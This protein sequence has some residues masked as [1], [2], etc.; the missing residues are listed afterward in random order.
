MSSDSSVIWVQNRLEIISK[1]DEIIFGWRRPL[2]NETG[3]HKGESEFFGKE[4]AS[5]IDKYYL[6]AD[7]YKW[8][9]IKGLASYRNGQIYEMS[10]RQIRV[11]K[12]LA[13]NKVN[14][15]HDECEQLI[16]ILEEIVILDRD[17][18]FFFNKKSVIKEVF[19]KIYIRASQSSDLIAVIYLARFLEL[20]VSANPE[21]FDNL[22]VEYCPNNILYADVLSLLI[23]YLNNA[24]L[25]VHDRVFLLWVSLQIVDSKPEIKVS[26]KL[27]E[28]VNNSLTKIA[29]YISRTVSVL[30]DPTFK[31]TFKLPDPTL[32][33]C[34]V[35][36]SL[37]ATN[38]SL[39]LL[40]IISSSNSD[41]KKFDKNIP[42]YLDQLKEGILVPYLKIFNH[43]I[44]SRTTNYRESGIE[45]EDSFLFPENHISNGIM[46]I[47]NTVNR[48]LS[49]MSILLRSYFRVGSALRVIDPISI[50]K[51]D[52]DNT[53]RLQLTHACWKREV[54]YEFRNW[55]SHA[56][57]YRR[58][59]EG[60]ER[61]SK[62]LN[63]EINKLRK[64]KKLVKFLSISF[65]SLAIIL[66]IIARENIDLKWFIPVI[67]SLLGAVYQ[68]A[69]FHKKP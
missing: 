68:I 12:F 6:T 5:E 13:D 31:Q 3:N 61:K 17:L 2:D 63:H 54:E 64:L 59:L 39:F 48:R 42:E 21:K 34:I 55:N 29:D 51:F 66:L 14:F 32:E 69:T 38:M 28:S 9:K 26:K 7:V 65:P 46:K 22:F 49:A 47:K 36:A 11:E 4:D 60:E 53:L 44:L 25:S 1:I 67:I 52:I 35:S 57:K 41:Y 27:V 43:E 37:V 33:F 30:A 18:E 16:S 15:I 23:S 45:N 20:I 19:E 24:D 10:P 56:M 40:T 58:L 62:K 8:M 50:S